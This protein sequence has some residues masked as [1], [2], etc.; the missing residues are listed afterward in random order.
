MNKTK[1][2]FI[3]Q[4]DQINLNVE[5]NQIKNQ[6]NYNKALNIK[7]PINKKRNLIISLSSISF[8]CACI[9]LS[10]VLI[11]NN[12]INNKAYLDIANK[13]LKLEKQS[14]SVIVENENIYINYSMMAIGC[15][16]TDELEFTYDNWQVYQNGKIIDKE[17]VD[18]NIGLNEYEIKLFRLNEVE[19]DYKLEIR[20]G[21]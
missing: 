17:H 13:E 5:F 9:I 1:K 3:K 19:E 20:V 18:L 10:F 8:A 16:L 15:D 12:N 2:Q 21:E 14:E 4:I 7:K 6:I 11:I